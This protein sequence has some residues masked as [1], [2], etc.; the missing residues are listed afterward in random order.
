MEK[1]LHI[2]VA[3][4]L[5]FAVGLLTGCQSS[6][7]GSSVE[8]GT[9]EVEHAKSVRSSIDDI[10][11]SLDDEGVE[12]VASGIE[13]TVE[14]LAIYDDTPVGSHR[15]TYEK[16]HQLAT[17]LKDLLQG[18]PSEEEIQQKIDEMKAAAEELPQE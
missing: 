4:T 17:E 3:C 16:I 14:S 11:R 6:E 9:P 2:A 8:V 5:T 13:G 15:E 7:S 18:S 10:Q 1:L 12:S